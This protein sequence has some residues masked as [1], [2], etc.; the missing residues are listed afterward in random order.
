MTCGSLPGGNNPVEGP[1]DNYC[2]TLQ[3]LQTLPLSPPVIL[4]GNCGPALTLELSPHLSCMMVVRSEVRAGWHYIPIRHKTPRS[5]PLTWLDPHKNWDF[6]IKCQ[7]K[8]KREDHWK[9]RLGFATQL[10]WYL[11]MWETEESQGDTGG[12]LESFLDLKKNNQTGNLG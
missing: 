2:H 3:T 6:V 11:S 9:L 8:I 10:S 4:I 7:N 1:G 12:S 5:A